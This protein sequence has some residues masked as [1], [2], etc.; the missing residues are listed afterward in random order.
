MSPAGTGEPNVTPVDFG[1]GLPPEIQ[2]QLDELTRR[3]QIAMAMQQ[4]SMQPIQMPQG[5]PVASRINPLAPL[6]QAMT[7]FMAGRD[8]SSAEGEMNKVRGQYQTQTSDEIARMLA[9]PDQEGVTAGLSSRNPIVQALAHQR[10]QQLEG[11]V[12]EAVGAVKESSPA[13]ALTIA[14]TGNI[15]DSPLPAIPG[16]TFGAQGL[17]PYAITSNQKGEQKVDWAPIQSTGINIKLPGYEAQA[18]LETLKSELKERRDLAMGSKE[19]LQSGINPAIEALNAGASSGGLE[20]YKQAIRK[21]AGAFGIP[22]DSTTSTE[23]LSMALGQQVLANARKLAPVTQE[24]VKQLQKDLGSITTDPQALR[25][26]LVRTQ[27]LHVQN[28]DNFNKYVQ[29]QSSN[30]ETPYARDL[31]KG[32]TIGFETPPSPGLTPSLADIQEERRRR[33]GR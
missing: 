7:G 28:L 18:A 11:R 6:L 19:A 33:G 5:G 15:D 9:M 17:N 29:S 26:M 31:F 24:D 23:Q 13:R 27:K 12:K 2:Q 20:N 10:R 4:R 25:R 16:P 30:L 14:K 22:F 1:N 32:S 21:V 8:A 3:R